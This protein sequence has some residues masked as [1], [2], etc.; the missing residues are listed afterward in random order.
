MIINKS[1]FFKI[2]SKNE[3]SSFKKAL[4]HECWM[5]EMNMEYEAL[6]NQTYNLVPYPNESNVIGNK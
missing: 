5:N 3:P 4:K 6:M 2:D 1:L